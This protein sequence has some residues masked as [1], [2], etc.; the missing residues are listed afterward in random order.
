M[1]KYIDESVLN[2]IESSGSIQI[3][4]K[5]LSKDISEILVHAKR[6]QFNSKEMDVVRKKTK[7]LIKLVQ[8][9]EKLLKA[10]R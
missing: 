2:E 3:K 10:V 6:M 5:N 8:S 4:L 1:E 9:S 7:E